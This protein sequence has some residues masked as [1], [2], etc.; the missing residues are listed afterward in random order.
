LYGL[1]SDSVEGK[2]G[3]GSGGGSDSLSHQTQTSLSTKFP[4][5]PN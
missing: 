2:S 5:N 4:P 3:G 1:M